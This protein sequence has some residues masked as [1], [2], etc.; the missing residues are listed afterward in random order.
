MK[1]A[2]PPLLFYAIVDNFHELVLRFLYT[3][4]IVVKVTV[5]SAFPVAKVP[6]KIV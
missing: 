1:C 3:L 4:T 2:V 6:L 5:R